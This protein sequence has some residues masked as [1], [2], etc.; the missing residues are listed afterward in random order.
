[1]S[2]L[3]R[4]S[5]GVAF[6]QVYDPARHLS[7]DVYLDTTD[8]TH[9]ARGQME[10]LLKRV[11]LFGSSTTHLHTGANTYRPHA[12]GEVV[13]EGRMVETSCYNTVEVGFRDSGRRQ[14]S[15][16]LY[17]NEEAKPPTRKTSGK[18]PPPPPF[19]NSGSEQS[20][21]DAFPRAQQPCM[22]SAP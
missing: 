15:L 12:Q 20:I 10:W 5:Y 2:R 4:Y 9:R 22:R 18:T 13:E 8:G 3:S 17:Y 21:T 7:E 1:M 11:S 14:F 16:N 6:T 19:P